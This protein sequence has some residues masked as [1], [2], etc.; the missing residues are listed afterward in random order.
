[1]LLIVDV[2][3]LE[4]W[5]LW[6]QGLYIIIY[7]YLPRTLQCLVHATH[8]TYLLSWMSEW[9][10]EWIKRIIPILVLGVYTGLLSMVVQMVHCTY[11][12]W[13]WDHFWVKSDVK[14]PPERL[15]S[16]YS[17][18]L[19]SLD[20]GFNFIS[21]GR[22]KESNTVKGD[23]GWSWTFGPCFLSWDK[24]GEAWRPWEDCGQS[25]KSRYVKEKYRDQ[26]FLPL[27]SYSGLNLFLGKECLQPNCAWI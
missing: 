4:V 25:Q 9:T 26:F 20:L 17:V 13:G 1:M 11:P 12:R 19:Y 6:R 5:V 7:S 8:S 23:G 10:D 14:A 16:A 22:N 15:C 2:S 24:L 3:R 27:P 18:Q 21:S